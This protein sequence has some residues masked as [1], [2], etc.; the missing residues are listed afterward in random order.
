MLGRAEANAV[1]LGTSLANIRMGTC[2]EKETGKRM[3]SDRNVCCGNHPYVNCLRKDFN[4][5][6][7]RHSR[8]LPESSVMLVTC[9]ADGRVDRPDSF[10]HE[11]TFDEAR[12]GKGL[13]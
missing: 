1:E 13:V 5:H 8:H 2:T 6:S 4:R 10:E 9:A 12:C 7:R 11:R 3:R